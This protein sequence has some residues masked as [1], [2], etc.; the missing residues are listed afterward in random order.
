[1][2][3]VW[4]EHFELHFIQLIQQRS[5]KPILDVNV[6]FNEFQ[7]A[8]DR[9]KQSFWVDMGE[10]MRVKPKKLHDYFHNTWS[11]KFYDDLE[12]YKNFVQ[13]TISKVHD[14]DR[15]LLMRNVLRTLQN[16]Y[17]TKKFHYQTLYQ[18]VNYKLRQPS[19]PRGLRSLTA[20][21]SSPAFFRKDSMVENRSGLSQMS[22]YSASVQDSCD[23]EDM[24]TMDDIFGQ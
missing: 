19:G 13:E 17:P 21:A 4:Q 16:T 2:S 1:M 18:F 12:P 8:D 5:V 20:S 6:A 11:K 14:E 23:E 3:E 7:Q 9:I 24:R 10:M 22:Q 15:K